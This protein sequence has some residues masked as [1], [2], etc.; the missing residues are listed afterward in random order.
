MFLSH[1]VRRFLRNYKPLFAS[2]IDQHFVYWKKSS[3]KWVHSLQQFK[4]KR[5]FR[6]INKH[7]KK[8]LKPIEK[9]DLDQ[10]VYSRDTIRNISNILRYSTWDSAQQQ[11][12]KLTIRWDSYTVNQ[13]L[14]THP[15]ME[16]AW[17]FFNWASRLKGFKHDQFT[18][19]TM[20][21]IFGE[22]RRISSMRYV[23]EQMQEKGIKVDVVTYTSLLHWFSNDGDVDGAVRIWEEMKTRCCD[24]TVVS[25]T[26]YMKVLFDHNR[27][28]EATKVYKEML[29]SGCSPNCYTYTVLM[30][31]LAGSVALLVCVQKDYYY[32]DKIPSLEQPCPFVILSFELNW[33]FETWSTSY[34]AT[35]KDAA[36][37]KE[38]FAIIKEDVAT[39][40]SD[41]H[42]IKT[43]LNELKASMEGLL[44]AVLQKTNIQGQKDDSVEDFE[45]T[46]KEQD[47]YAANIED[48]EERKAK[49]N[50]LTKESM[51]DHHDQCSNAKEVKEN[52]ENAT[53]L[54]TLHKKNEVHIEFII[55]DKFDMVNGVITTLNFLIF[56]SFVPNN[57][58]EWLQVQDSIILILQHYK[59][60]GRV[61][62]NGGEN[63]K[64]H[65]KKKKSKSRISHEAHL[66][67]Q[68]LKI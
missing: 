45:E 66:E 50:L 63:D 40:K 5:P 43:T 59:T 19:T 24:P 38:D 15:P 54:S 27:V 23:F 60:R 55:P 39:M 68:E 52:D 26:A 61:F 35:N 8:P 58:V 25:F 32:Q 9:R 33:K 64:D 48:I 22:A 2:H 14:K 28:K 4:Q 42:T 34:R 37:L 53:E 62:S 36:M 3:I 6:Q 31:H 49:N 16:K 57:Q 7:M 18:C 65:G 20:L 29:Q 30:E 21:D 17:L 1:G 41:V 13:V 11:L 56:S 44:A 46:M 10:K 51:K 47:E 67:Y 12:E